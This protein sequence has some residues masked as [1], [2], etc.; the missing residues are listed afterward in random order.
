MVVQSFLWSSLLELKNTHIGIWEG[1]QI[2]HLNDE[3]R[4]KKFYPKN[5]SGSRR[6]ANNL[7]D[8][9]NEFHEFSAL[10]RKNKFGSF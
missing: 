8:I 7:F 5:Q 2:D 3:I 1:Q 4:C 6:V 9:Q 10:S